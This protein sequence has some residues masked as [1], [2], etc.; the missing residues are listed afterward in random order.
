M[1]R[2][3]YLIGLLLI[4]QLVMLVSNASVK[5]EGTRSLEVLQSINAINQT[6]ILA[7]SHG[8]NGDYDIDA[9]ALSLDELH[10][11]SPPLGTLVNALN[12]AELVS[13]HDKSKT[14]KKVT[15]GEYH[16][17]LAPRINELISRR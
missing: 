1:M 7:K 3:T 6:L 13:L 12:D 17:V 5:H 16:A 9:V 4:V 15:P 8:Y 14:D 11:E 10:L 2:L